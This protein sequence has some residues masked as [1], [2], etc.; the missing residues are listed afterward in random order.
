MKRR[1][2][3]ALALAGAAALPSLDAL[4]QGAGT[5]AST[6]ADGK[7]VLRI[8]F[9]VAETGF[10]P[11]KVSDV[12][13]ATVNGHIFEALYQFDYLARPVKLKPRL[14]VGMPE[15]SADFRVW[16]VRIQPGVY[17]NDDPAFKGQKRELVA[18]DIIYSLKRFADLANKSPYWSSLDEY[19]ITG[20]LELR[21][22][23]V[24]DKKPFDYDTEIEGLRAL[25]RHTLR[26]T[27]DQTRPRFNELLALSSTF[28]T[29]AREV[30]EF[31]GDLSPAHPVGTGPFRLAQWRRSSLIVLERNPNYREVLW[32]AEPGADDAEGQAILQRMKGRRL[33][34]VDRVEVSVVEEAQPRWLSFL[35]G[36]A[37]VLVVPQEFAPVAMPGGRMAPNLKKKG[38]QGWRVLVPS[39]QLSFFNMDHPVVGGLE[40]HK[41][42][43]RRAIALSIN[44]QR[45]IQL[46][47]RGEAMAAQS[48]ISPH[49][50]GYNADFKSENS[51]YSP[52]RARALLDLYGYVDSDGD[53]WRE[54][55]D[56]SPLKLECATQPDGLSRQ[57]NELLKKSLDAVGVRVVFISAKWPENLKAARAGKLMY[58]RVGSTSTQTD[59]QDILSRL[60]GPQIGQGNLARFKL[61]AF[62]E[63]YRQLTSLPDGPEREAVFDKAKRLAIAYMPYKV[64]VHQYVT[65]LAHPWLS[66]YRRPLFWY[67]LW[68]L[69][70]V[71]MQA[72][73]AAGTV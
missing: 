10:D 71:D 61:P 4:A 5:A 31:Y 63:V 33:P 65:V 56:G 15:V 59:G 35:N 12:Y 64:H 6:G 45:E 34:L 50:S 16:T 18:Q 73:T 54:Q 44:V 53:G 19:G 25:D 66:G 58:W 39:T 13:S 7:K 30:I 38:V 36:Q 27:L 46:A 23:G 48:I 11:A 69:L 2:A 60:Y 43:L 32:D 29:V 40:P 20:L 52:S 67:D 62:D 3:L 26:F 49:L 9:P 57:F 14:A 41:V 24:K 8:I 22:K 47:Y 68:H 55:P 17:F 1:Q 72:R 42:A 21:N 37:D 51:E 70:D 28:G